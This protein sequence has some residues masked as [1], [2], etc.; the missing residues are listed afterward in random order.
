ME[1]A[2]KIQQTGAKIAGNTVKP[3]GVPGKNKSNNFAQ[4]VAHQE[5]E[6]NYANY[7]VAMT[8][9]QDAL[10]YAW[11]TTGH[12]SDK[13]NK[14]GIIK[15]HPRDLLT[16]LKDTFIKGSTKDNAIDAA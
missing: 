13:K 2:N 11:E 12:F 14:V 7:K 8:F 10:E 9:A 16:F 3:P 6:R 15:D 1:S 4:L 5:K